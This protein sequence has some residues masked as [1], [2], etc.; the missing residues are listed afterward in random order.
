VCKSPGIASP[1]SE[2]KLEMQ[3]RRKYVARGSVITLEAC[4]IDK[5]TGTLCD[6]VI[7]NPISLVSDHGCCGRI[8]ALGPIVPMRMQL[9]V[10]EV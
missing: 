7:C 3:P 10:Y 2:Q 4:R 8:R 6:A 1:R 5:V 9:E